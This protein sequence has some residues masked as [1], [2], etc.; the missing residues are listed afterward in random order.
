MICRCSSLDPV[1]RS[2]RFT[3][4]GQTGEGTGTRV[5]METSIS[6]GENV[7]CTTDGVSTV[8][9]GTEAGPDTIV[10]VD[11]EEAVRAIVAEFLQE[12]GYHVLQADGG[13]AALRLLEADPRIRLLVT[14][15]RMPEMSGV[16]LADQATAIRPALKIILISGYFV[17]QQVKRRLLRKP[18]RMR[19][20]A[21]AVRDELGAPA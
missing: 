21:A 6:R 11:D 4:T 1:L 20:L 3:R 12:F 5:M 2:R 7:S 9:R 19:E 15:I 16:E 8:D 10:V 17:A 18:F 13:A 14:D